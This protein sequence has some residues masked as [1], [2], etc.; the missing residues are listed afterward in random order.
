MKN[1]NILEIML[2]II[3]NEQNIINTEQ[4]VKVI[5][6]LLIKK[7][8]SFFFEGLINNSNYN[9][10]HNSD[11][12]DYIQQIENFIRKSDKL[13]IHS[14]HSTLIYLYSH[15]EGL[16]KFITSSNLRYI[17]D[18]VSS[19]SLFYDLR[20]DYARLLSR[21]S[22]ESGSSGAYY[23]PTAI[24]ELLTHDIP[25]FPSDYIYDPAC[26]TSGLLLSAFYNTKKTYANSNL[27]IFGK[28]LSSFSCLLS[29]CN[30]LI[31]NIGNFSIECGNS[32]QCNNL[33][34]KYNLIISNPP[35]GKINIYNSNQAHKYLEYDFLEHI[36]LSLENNGNAVVILPNRFF[37]DENH[38][39]ITLK[40]KLLSD[41]N[42]TKI[43]SLPA[44]VFL[45]YTAV[46]TSILFFSKSG[47]TKKIL[48]HDASTQYK[49][50]K[51][52]PFNISHT[53]EIISSLAQ[54]K[55]SPRTWILNYEDLSSNYNFLE[56]P[57]T[58]SERLNFNI[59]LEQIDSLD[60]NLNVFDDVL[61]SLKNDIKQLKNDLDNVR[62]SSTSIKYK[63]NDILI[64]KT[65]L[66]L[67]KNN[68]SEEGK[69]PVFGGNGIIGYTNKAKEFGETIVIGKVGALCGNVRYCNGD[70]W[71][72]NNSMIVKNRKDD[73]VYM[74][75]L[76]KLL[77]AMELRK[78]SSGTAQ[79]YITVR[80][81][82]SIDINLP[83]IEIQ[84]KIDALLCQIENKINTMV[85]LKEKINSCSI[86]ILN[87]IV[88][89][90]QIIK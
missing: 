35:F 90:L 63:L 5:S 39:A 23:T 53:Q 59:S 32:I 71:V 82:K 62:T 50:T 66:L 85:K 18:D 49:I 2:D 20:E 16:D 51:S 55:N 28:D 77:K 31:N 13:Y 86:H 46:K 21:M 34:H 10:A 56:R 40:K 80:H 89:N 74:P 68:L 79:Q 52:N 30:M 29:L 19:L 44:G 43:I 84:I 60:D 3:K 76:A 61:F 75:Y 78:L 81:I 15:F 12:I 14:D 45:P 17:L 4:A 6:C 8:L 70:I 58:H 88:C 36:M 42:V 22:D 33:D 65:G 69:I 83:S 57:E 64:I 11:I 67:Q 48:V 41:F 47:H 54:N 1:K 27:K 87:D 26:G 7:Y 25:S 37:S 38:E 24:C 72:T 73:I 9:N